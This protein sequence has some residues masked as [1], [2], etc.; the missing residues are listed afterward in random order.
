MKRKRP[1]ND[2]ITTSM[3]YFIGITILLAYLP[4]NSLTLIGK[5]KTYCI[6]QSMT[7][8]NARVLG[9]DGQDAKRSE[10]IGKFV[11]IDY[12]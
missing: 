9:R 8:P 7:R 5:P 11:V 1:A 10:R 12:S 3:A 2:E 6:R 4:S